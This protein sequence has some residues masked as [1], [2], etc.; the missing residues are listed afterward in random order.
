MDE[1]EYIIDYFNIEDAHVFDYPYS[2][3]DSLL[4]IGKVQIDEV[5]H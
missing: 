5:L 3:E 2:Y 1:L 4:A